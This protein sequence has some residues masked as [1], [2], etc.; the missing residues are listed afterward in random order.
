LESALGAQAGHVLFSE[1]GFGG[2]S[3]AA[4]VLQLEPAAN[5]PHRQDAED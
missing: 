4:G 3:T 1:G 2:P 5:R